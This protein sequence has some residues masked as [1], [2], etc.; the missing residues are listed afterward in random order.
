ME[1]IV[2]IKTCFFYL[3]LIFLVIPT[4]T[5]AM[6]KRQHT[7]SR[8]EYTTEQTSKIRRPKGRGF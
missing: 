4:S 5:F 7:D 8:Q 6:R 3:F 2:K 1:V